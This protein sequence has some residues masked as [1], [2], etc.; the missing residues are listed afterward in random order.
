M[1][2]SKIV[3]TPNKSF[4]SF[5]ILYSPLMANFFC[6]CKRTVPWVSACN[7]SSDNYQDF[8]WNSE[9]TFLLGP[10]KSSYLELSFLVVASVVYFK[11]CL[12]YLLRSISNFYS[13][14]ATEST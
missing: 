5:F 14:E 13:P 11:V 1:M 3:S 6:S 12:Q 8:L 9:H 7:D 2:P 4:D 10:G